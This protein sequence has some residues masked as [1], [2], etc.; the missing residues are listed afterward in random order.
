MNAE[1]NAHASDFIR[2]KIKARV[3]NREVARKLL[4]DHP[5]GTKRVPLESGYYE[6][7]NRTNVRLVDLRETP[8]ERITPAG[9]RTSAEEQRLDVII[10]ATGFDAGTGALTRI[11]IRGEAGL[12]LA[13]KWA[14]APRLSSVY[15]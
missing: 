9:I 5:F 10:Y 8:I 6:V 11:D 7:Y 4:P 12:S 2:T 15:S 13:E 14:M 1:V 3:H